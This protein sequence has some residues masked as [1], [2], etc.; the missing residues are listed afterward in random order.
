M[1]IGEKSIL[2]CRADYAYGDNP[3]PGGKIKPGDNLL[4]ECE[5]LDFGPKKKE[6]WE[7]T[8]KEKIEEAKKLK[9]QGTEKFKNKEFSK[10]AELYEEASTYVEKFSGDA[11]SDSSAEDEIESE[12]DKTINHDEAVNIL[13]SCHLNAAQAHLSSKQW[14]NAISSANKAL[15]I[16]ENNIKALFRRGS[17]RRHSGLF[18]EAK[19][20]ILEILKID[21]TNIAAKKE[22]F[23]IKEAVKAAKKKEKATFGGL[24]GKVSMYDDKEGLIVPTGSCPKVFFDIK[25]GDENAG[26]II[27]ELWSHTTPKT[28]ENFRALCT[29]EK[30]KAS[31]GQPLHY[32]GCTF[33]RVI[34]NFMI[35]GGD[36][37]LGNGMGGE[38]I[39]GEKFADENF[40]MKHTEPYLL[41]MANAGP[42][43]N[44]SQFFIT[45]KDTPHL[46]GKHVVF[47]KV[48]EGIEIIRKIENLP[49]DSSDKPNEQVIIADCGEMIDED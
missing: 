38:S 33:H 11:A 10:A 13:L 44:G 24:F 17:A 46:D 32:K 26:K 28:A 37:T 48:L 9:E 7:M 31:T 3:S 41:S 43:T 42:G 25:I 22:L 45:L 15:S 2:K 30:G 16:E 8:S 40:K 49:T 39:Y 21:E 19:R 5:L 29:G 6:K 18:D 35:Q 36:F 23:L 47:G 14:V 12:N 1:K 34:K 27:M 20:D 4:F